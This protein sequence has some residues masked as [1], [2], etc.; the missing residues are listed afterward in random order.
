MNNKLKDIRR[1]EV[2]AQIKVT[3]QDLSTATE[4]N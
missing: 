2:V 4:E 1:E 3:P